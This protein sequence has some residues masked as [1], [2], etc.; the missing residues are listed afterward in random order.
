[1]AIRAG[2]IIQ[3]EFLRLVLR[4]LL[5]R[6]VGVEIVGDGATLADAARLLPMPRSSSWSR[7]CA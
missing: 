5:R 3:T 4:Q 6:K 7:R 1:M 2:L